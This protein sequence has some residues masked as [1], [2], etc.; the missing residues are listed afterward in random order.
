MNNKQLNIKP[1]VLLSASPR[2]HQI[3]KKFN[4]EYVFKEH[5]F[6]EKSERYLNYKKPRDYVKSI[7]KKKAMSI[8]IDRKLIHMS[9][10]TIV[11]F[12]NT[13]FE[14]PDTIYEA[15][16]MLKQLSNNT[17]SV[18]TACCFIDPVTAKSY[19]RSWKTLVTFNP[20]SNDDIEKYVF[21]GNSLD[22]AGGY[23]IQDIPKSFIKSIKGSIYNV[24]G[25]QIHGVIQ[26]L[27]YIQES[28][29]FV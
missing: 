8:S 1:I 5:V 2:R 15:K 20:L 3:L 19:L 17:H 23:G 22:K 21:T 29:N 11:I 4:I 6:N 12:K 10:D 28:R 13:V 14:K 27:K 16:K 9:A 7:A 24:I 25:L 18:I 26:T